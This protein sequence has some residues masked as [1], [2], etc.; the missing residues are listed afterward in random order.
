MPQEIEGGGLAALQFERKHRT[1]V[2]ALCCINSLLLRAGKQGRI[3]D[4][5][6]FWVLRQLFCD[7]L[8]VLARASHSQP[9]RGQAPR[10]HPA[11]IGLEDRTKQPTPRR[12]LPD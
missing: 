4:A 12:D 10:Q 5:Y 6:G 8:G 9:D 7:S 3:V 11:L 2:V 1:R